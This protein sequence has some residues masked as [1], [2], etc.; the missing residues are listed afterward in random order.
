M[1]MLMHQRNSSSSVL[2][3]RPITGQKHHYLSIHQATLAPLEPLPAIDDKTD[4]PKESN[5]LS[6]TLSNPASKPLLSKLGPISSALPPPPSSPKGKAP[7]INTSS[8]K[9]SASLKPKPPPSIITSNSQPSMPP[10]SRMVAPFSRTTFGIIQTGNRG[11]ITGQPSGPIIDPDVP[12]IA[13]F[14]G[15]NL[16]NVDVKFSALP[17]LPI[18]GDPKFDS[19]LKS[20]IE[21][22]SCILDFTN[23]NSQVQEK[24]IKA[25][26]LCEL[27]EL[28]EN[29][30]HINQLNDEQQTMIF[31]MLDKNIFQQDYNIRSPILTYDKCNPLTIVEP[32]WSHLFYCY[33]ILNR[34][35]QIFPKSKHINIELARKAINLTQLP[36]ANERMQLVAFL[37][38]YFD[39]HQ[40]EQKAILELVKK[41]LSDQI[42]ITTTPFCAMPL[43]IFLTH[44]YTRFFTNSSIVSTDY[45]KVMN[46]GVLP[47]IGLPDLP[48]Y[49]QNLR[50]L[51]MTVLA[52]HSVYATKF[53]R[54]IELKWPQTSS[55]MQISTFNI[56]ISIFERM[57]QKDFKPMAKRVFHFIADCADSTNIKLQELALDIWRNASMDNWIGLNGRA[58]VKFMYEIALKLSEKHW[59][60][61]IVEKA[62]NALT[63]MCR[64]NKKEYQ[65]MKAYINQMKVKRL[66]P[67][68]PNDAQKGWAA[69]AKTAAELQTQ[70]GQK[71]DFDLNAKL[72]E[73]YDLF[74]NEK[75]PTL[76]VS[77]F[78]PVLEKHKNEKS[79]D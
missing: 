61:S 46:E 77:R 33:Q 22:C 54:Y 49:Q 41:K 10:S 8:S 36:D 12:N 43:I 79:N 45:M 39:T 78:V 30:R 52:G 59:N 63:E 11:K 16:F 5:E 2:Q 76:M 14:A 23:I 53:L 74:H 7:K 6:S 37:R 73:F 40:N 57:D 75:K 15:A 70:K 26:T 3:T 48:L 25:R 34:F 55:Q 64:I 31:D 72:K 60:K 62:G 19:L 68:I 47:L 13:R 21:I 56:I 44:I 29:T 66:K 4:V 32:C 65:K 35:V 9:L 67:R 38:T 24:E 50:Q 27:I 51:L 58:A 1:T 28:F 42:N 17:P 18:Y 71:I 20:K 69:I